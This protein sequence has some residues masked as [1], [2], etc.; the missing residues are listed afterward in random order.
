MRVPKLTPVYTMYLFALLLRAACVAKRP[1]CQRSVLPLQG[2]EERLDQRR[3]ASSGGGW[4]V[5]PI[6][7][8]MIGRVVY[9]MVR[10][11]SKTSTQ[12]NLRR[13]WPLTK[14]SCTSILWT[15]FNIRLPLLVA[16][17][18]KS[19]TPLHCSNDAT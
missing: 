12:V 15:C 19:A 8:T 3:V 9:H 16:S 4:L 13:L 18:R 1:M 6:E 11:R 5:V 10:Y 7:A 17:H 14:S 2:I